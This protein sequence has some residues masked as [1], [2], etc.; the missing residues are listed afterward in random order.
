MTTARGAPGGRLVDRHTVG[1]RL[2]DVSTGRTHQLRVRR[3]AVP[4]VFVPGVMG[5]RLN[6]SNAGRARQAW[7][8]DDATFMRRRYLSLGRSRAPEKKETRIGPG[9]FAPTWLQVSRGNETYGPAKRADVHAAR[10]GLT[11]AEL[12]HGWG[13]IFW[14]SYGPFLRRLAADSLGSRFGRVGTG[15][16]VETPV[17]AFGYNWTASAVQTGAQLAARIRAIV[18]EV[19]AQGLQC[20]GVVLVT[21]SMGGLVARSACLL[22]GAGSLVVGVVHAVQPVTGSA[23]AY[24][25]MK[26]GFERSWVAHPLDAIHSLALG[27]DGREVTAILGN[28]PGAVELLP[29]QNYSG[30]PNDPQWLH[31]PEEGGGETRLPRAGD[32]YAEIYRERTAPWRLIEDPTWLTPGV[33]QGATAVPASPGGVAD[34]Y[35]R[36]AGATT[37]TPTAPT[38][39]PSSVAAWN[40]Y[41]ANL[42]NAQSFHARMDARQHPR[43]FHVYATGLGTAGVIRLEGGPVRH[44]LPDE[45]RAMIAALGPASRASAACAWLTRGRTTPTGIRSGARRAG[46][47][48]S[49]SRST[50][51]C[52]RTT[53]LGRP[54]ASSRLRPASARCGYSAR[55]TTATGRSR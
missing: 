8:P 41:T 44:L 39:P 40:A 51:R 7:D 13:G 12:A 9:V 16:L 28:M 43:T 20:R 2:H 33:G 18:Q 22:H 17:Y 42:A 19:T 5:S 54:V 37:P 52:P 14:G 34:P 10:I 32:P 30:A 45:A 38:L 11:D 6:L 1:R 50:S 25:R 26:A 47:A 31:W 21:H 23:A 29:S 35:G 36:A 53:R 15:P 55:R 48:T 4:I 3:E 27:R 24:W 49:S 46:T